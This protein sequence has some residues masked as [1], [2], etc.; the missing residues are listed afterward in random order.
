MLLQNNVSPAS[1]I[2]YRIMQSSQTAHFARDMKSYNGVPGRGAIFHRAMMK[3]KKSEPKI[4]EAEGGRPTGC[5]FHS[6]KKH[7]SL[8]ST[9]AASVQASEIG[10]YTPKYVVTCFTLGGAK[11][12]QQEAPAE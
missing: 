4:K 9:A 8:R 2:Q 12:V 3:K 11:K 6:Y 10:T 5:L 7:R 1:D